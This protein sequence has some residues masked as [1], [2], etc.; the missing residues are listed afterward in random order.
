M[1]ES[2][3]RNQQRSVPGGV[4]GDNIRPMPMPM[5]MPQPVQPQPNQNVVDLT[6]DDGQQ[7]LPSSRYLQSQTGRPTPGPIAF[8]RSTGMSNPN[9][10]NRPQPQG[11][12]LPPKNKHAEPSKIRMID[13]TTNKPS[14]KGSNWDA[15]T[16]SQPSSQSNSQQ[17]HSARQFMRDGAEVVKHALKDGFARAQLALEQANH[18]Q[19]KN[20]RPLPYSNGGYRPNHSSQNGNAF[21]VNDDD[22]D[23]D[24]L[25][26][27]FGGS[28]MTAEERDQQLQ[29][30]LNSMVLPPELGDIDL[31]KASNVKGLSCKL[32]PH[33]VA[34]YLWLKGREGGKHKGG[35]LADDM[36]LGKTVQML[37]LI[38]GNS[39]NSEDTTITKIRIEPEKTTKKSK[40]KVVPDSDDAP[41]KEESVEIKSKQTL[42]IAPLA[43]IRQ[44]E[45]EIKEKTSPPLKVLV[46]H[47]ATRTK[48][49][50]AFKRYDVV[51]TTYP[52]IASEWNNVAGVEKPKKKGQ[53]KKNVVPDS[54]EE[55]ESESDD[56]DSD[57][58]FEVIDAKKKKAAKAPVKKLPPAPLFDHDWLR[59]VLDEAQ[60]IKNHRTKASSACSALSKRALSKWCLSGTPIQNEALEM[61]SLIR[62]LG[63]PPFDEYGHFREKISDPLKSTNQNRVTWGMKRLCAVLT[64]IMLRR[65]K[66]TKHDGKPILNLPDRHVEV[67][68]TDFEDH[69]ERDFYNDLE[70]QVKR[71][72]EEA[73]GAG[74]KVNHMVTLLMLL[75]LRQACSH[76]SLVNRNVRVDA[77]AANGPA[78][79][80]KADGQGEEQKVDDDD[81]GLTE[82]LAGLSVASKRC[83]RC[84]KEMTREEIAKGG[85]HCR[86][87][88]DRIQAEKM[89][90]GGKSAWTGKS[91]TKIRTMLRLLNTIREEGD[92]KTIVFSQF[93]SFLDLVE[94]FLREEGHKF[95][96]Y[97]GSLKPEERERAL[98]R[99]RS[100]PSIRLILISFKAGNVGLNLTC[101][102]RVILMDLWWN[103]M[104]EAQ[105]IDRAHRLGQ[106]RNVH[107]YKLVIN[108]SV[109]ER[110]L[111]LQ[112]K[113]RALAEAALEGSKLSKANKLDRKELMYLFSGGPVS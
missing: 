24:P 69:K 67:I 80:A 94:P 60:N 92:E 5:P 25:P 105:S 14:E 43:V 79:Q 104:L 75:R 103:P 51:I 96:R 76:P 98:D 31:E 59:V 99:I 109:E 18:G 3:Q 107:V 113:K 6:K 1:M 82:L 54:S 66:D 9:N 85:E 90:G 12:Q 49:A 30:M 27:T 16:D 68:S 26:S 17:R 33:Q 64:T 2:F 38:V 110:I 93:T 61:F 87:C 11:R 89:Q 56:Q 78:I 28:T 10:P 58:S 111:A 42:I 15:F 73:E 71:N 101:C 74:T 44:W 53:Q 23:D 34:G 86:V 50:D 108:D 106:Q 63:I 19:A 62:F 36:G 21:I 55:D 81:D 100:D 57:D 41:V 29:D 97:D 72:L 91:S 37:A 7:P 40:K 48:T 112:D 52:T 32:M 95:V 22:V 45:R 70:N 20:P 88:Q 46:H 83:D 102:S 84:Q 65:T 77:G 35:I 4:R 8:K 47:G 13:T 39:P